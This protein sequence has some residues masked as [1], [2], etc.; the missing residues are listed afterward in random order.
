MYNWWMKRAKVE[1]YEWGMLKGQNY[2]LK[3]GHFKHK[4]VLEDAT[5]NCVSQNLTHVENFQKKCS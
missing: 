2:K 1:S 4:G 5:C 3:W